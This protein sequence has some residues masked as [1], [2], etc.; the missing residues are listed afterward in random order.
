MIIFSIFSVYSFSSSHLTL[1]FQPKD[2][3]LG[4]LL[5]HGSISA[6][7]LASNSDEPGEKLKNYHLYIFEQLVLFCEE[8]SKRNSYSPPV[9]IYKGHVSVRNSLFHTVDYFNHRSELNVSSDFV[10]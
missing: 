9:Y 10:S 1:Y 4:K 7:R 8:Q 3:T 5:K 6:A 2:F